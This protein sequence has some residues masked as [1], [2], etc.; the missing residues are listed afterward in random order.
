MIRCGIMIG[1][2]SQHSAQSS[3]PQV[4]PWVHNG[5]VIEKAKLRSSNAVKLDT[6][7]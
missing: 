4:A 1:S 3:L 5:K 2:G 6:W 7:P